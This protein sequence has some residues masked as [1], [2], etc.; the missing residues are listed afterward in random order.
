MQHWEE[1]GLTSEFKNNIS[2]WYIIA[3]CKQVE[4]SNQNKFSWGGGLE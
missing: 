2:K 1:K 3:T 4:P